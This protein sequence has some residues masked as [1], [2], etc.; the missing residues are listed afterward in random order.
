MCQFQKLNHFLTGFSPYFKLDN[1]NI[2][3]LFLQLLACFLPWDH[4]EHS[5]PVTSAFGSG[6]NHNLH[7]RIRF[8]IVLSLP[9]WRRWA[10]MSEAWQNVTL[11]AFRKTFQLHLHQKS[12]IR[13]WIQQISQHRLILEHTHAQFWNFTSLLMAMLWDLTSVSSDAV[14][15]WITDKHGHRRR[16]Q[17]SVNSTSESAQIAWKSDMCQLLQHRIHLDQPLEPEPQ[18]HSPLSLLFTGSVTRNTSSN[19]IYFITPGITWRWMAVTKE[20]ACIHCPL[21][22]G[23]D[24]ILWDRSFRTEL[25]LL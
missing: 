6:V 1:R 12:K 17:S 18:I 13:L 5:V 4:M 16:L 9:G 19:R 15:W 2:F 23:A 10:E 7:L 24:T 20:L 21:I 11:S 25:F 3:A 22:T 14:G 8:F